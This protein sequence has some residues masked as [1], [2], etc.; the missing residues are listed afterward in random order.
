MRNTLDFKR[1]FKEGFVLVQQYVN[2]E[3]SF[4]NKVVTISPEEL[5]T[6]FKLKLMLFIAQA[7]NVDAIRR[8]PQNRVV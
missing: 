8:N 5:I 7:D 6:K 3:I 2:M 1:G 4:R